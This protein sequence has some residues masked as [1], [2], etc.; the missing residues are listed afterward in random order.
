MSS[1]GE[2]LQ[3]A[4]IPRDE[5][6]LLAAFVMG[7][8][9]LWAIAHPETHLSPSQR[10]K[11]AVL[12]RR[13]S[14][15]TPIASLTGQRD[16][17]SRTFSVGSNVLIPRPETETLVESALHLLPPNQQ[18]LVVDV[19]TGSGCIAITI[20]KER[21]NVRLIGIDRSTRALVYARKNARRLGTPSI[22]WLHGHLLGPLRSQRESPDLLVAN[23]PYLTK[24]ES[25]RLIGEP[26]TALDGGGRDGLNLY[27]A[28]INQI[29][30][31]YRRIPALVFETDPRRARRLAALIRAR[32]PGHRTTI[33]ADLAG[34]PR[35]VVSRAP[36]TVEG[37]MRRAPGPRRHP[38]AHRSRRPLRP[39][40]TAARSRR[41]R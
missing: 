9:R 15:G 41:P 25:A 40:P 19:G 7:R 16:F 38:P 8:N 24:R 22:R 13:R 6:E 31:H 37:R 36:T 29:N 1:L 14:G 27:R 32:F 21:P 30:R 33:V 20:A 17:Y 34:R 28:L 39:R 2:L 11:L 12:I 10:K 23:L 5:A 35:V 26:K 3:R 18:W 4:F